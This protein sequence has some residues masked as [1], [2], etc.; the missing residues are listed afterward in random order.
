MKRTAIAVAL[1]CPL[2]ALAANTAIGTDPDSR[3]IAGDAGW[4][5][6]QRDGAAVEAIGLTRYVLRDE[7]AGWS[8]PIYRA[9]GA[10]PRPRVPVRGAA[11]DIDRAVPGVQS[12]KESISCKAKS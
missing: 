7:S 8:E 1:I 2:G 6:A 9:V 10:S 5:S 4:I 12:E 3:R 11:P